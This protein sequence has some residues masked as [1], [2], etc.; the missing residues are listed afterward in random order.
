MAN[1]ALVH[2]L[3]P[4]CAYYEEPVKPSDE[5][6]TVRA[7]FFYTSNIPIDDPLSPLPPPSDSKTAQQS[8]QPFSA[9]DN[10]AL[11]EAWQAKQKGALKGTRHGDLFH[12]PKFKG[13]KRT[14]EST[15]EAQYK[16]LEK[17]P[18][19]QAEMNDTEKGTP[20]ESKRL[21]LEDKR[22]N[23]ASEDIKKK[24]S[25]KKA[26]DTEHEQEPEDIKQNHTNQPPRL[27]SPQQAAA[28]SQKESARAT[29]HAP[30]AEDDEPVMLSQSTEHDETSPVVPVDA[31]ELATEQEVAQ[32][33]KPGRR[34][35][36]SPFRNR[37]KGSKGMF[38]TCH[39]LEERSDG[40]ASSDISGRP[41]ARAPSFRRRRPPPAVGGADSVT[42]SEGSP[43]PAR[44][45]KG[46]ETFVPVG[47]SRLHLV[48]MPA[49]LMKPI[50]WNPIN[51]I[52]NVTRGTWFYQD[53][54]LPVEQ[55]V[56]VQLEAGYEA[57]QPWVSHPVPYN[58]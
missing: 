13:Q 5:P 3:G 15:M 53:S 41:F 12:F 2:S 40:T 35:K 32:Q 11:E 43:S 54:M 26:E 28:H 17:P 51:D 31:K 55:E 48:E 56:T 18:S 50:Y 29:R 38:S 45:K 42:D 16:T 24:H 37:G 27:G 14:P 9:R 7:Q 30:E 22:Q 8:P 36:F 23:K 1:P 33:G 49:M 25:Q 39:D 21:Q 58:G 44:L 57:M 6:P 4:T 19:A 34:R 52:S 47:I 10:A 46:N 20:V